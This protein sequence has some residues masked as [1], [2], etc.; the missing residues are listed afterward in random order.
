MEM[1]RLGGALA[2]VLSLVMFEAYLRPCEM[3][4]L[5]PSS[6]LAP[7]RG[8]V[9]SWVV[10][11]FPQTAKERSK[12]GEADDTISLDSDRCQWMA[13][14]FEQM[15]RCQ[16]ASGRL[17]R[18]NYAEYLL[19]FRR[20]A[21]NL[22]IEM[23][24]YQGRHSGASVDRA[25]GRRSLEAIQKRGRW[26]STKSVRRYEKAG[27]VNQTWAELSPE[28]QAHCSRCE[29]ALAGVLLQGAEC[30]LPPGLRRCSW[31]R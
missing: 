11:L 21:A 25:E 24:P 29:R 17:L 2:G 4:S 15:A 27:R 16:P 12:T 7:A 8:G 13:P 20:A 10:L 22:G 23:V 14:I 18:M 9:P 31:E 26:R 3:L 28:V 5:T 30:P 19:I 1:C 6:F